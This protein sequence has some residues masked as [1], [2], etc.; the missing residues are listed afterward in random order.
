M[1][2]AN[3]MASMARVMAS[4][5]RAIGNQSSRSAW[6]RGSLGSGGMRFDQRMV[7]GGGNAFGQR[8]FAAESDK[9]ESKPVSPAEESLKE[10][11]KGFFKSLFQVEAAPEQTVPSSFQ[12]AAGLERAEIYDP[13]L[14]AHND[15]LEGPFGTPENPV[16]V[17]SCFESRIVGCTGDAA[18]DDHDLFW[19]EVPAGEIV[20][21]PLCGQ[22]FKLK[23]IDGIVDTSKE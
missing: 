2:V 18:P 13:K 16:L 20:T 14:F 23:Q 4:A 3:R 15:V 12:Q 17:E 8:T 10:Q 1:A 21:C 7:R 22:A 19:F 11:E 6:V 9:P 5:S